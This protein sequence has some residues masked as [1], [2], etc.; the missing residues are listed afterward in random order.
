M[1]PGFLRARSGPRWDGRV[2]PAG[3]AFRVVRGLRVLLVGRIREEWLRTSGSKTAG[4][5][6]QAATGRVIT[7]A[8]IIMICVFAAFVLA[9]SASLPGLASAWPP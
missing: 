4:S 3:D 8:A 9:A 2:V 7:A 5:G 1:G 6:G